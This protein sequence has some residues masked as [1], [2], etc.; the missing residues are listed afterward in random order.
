M[1]N[2]SAGVTRSA[3]A[4]NAKTRR[5]KPQDNVRAVVVMEVQLRDPVPG[6]YRCVAPLLP[7]HPQHQ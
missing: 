5:M 7:R 4:A 3:N 6:P 2:A 1:H